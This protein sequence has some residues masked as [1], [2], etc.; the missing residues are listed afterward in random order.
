MNS[1]FGEP[2]D[3]NMP[4]NMRHLRKPITYHLDETIYEKERV[5]I[6]ENLVMDLCI[7]LEAIVESGFL[8][9]LNENQK[10]FD[11]VLSTSN[12]STFFQ[13]GETFVDNRT[14]TLGHPNSCVIPDV[15]R[16]FLRLIPQKP[17]DSIKTS[18]IALDFARDG[19]LVP[20]SEPGL[21]WSYGRNKYGAYACFEQDGKILNLTQLFK[22]G[23][24]W[25]IDADCIE[26]T[27]LMERAKC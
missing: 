22:S 26:K 1:A 6:K 24:L 10:D 21:S 17:M 19:N 23:E 11:G 4:F 14:S 25:G 20:M 12:P 13:P 18:E 16:L 27:G 15:Q 8:T 2:T 9:Q 7:A 5:K 3:A